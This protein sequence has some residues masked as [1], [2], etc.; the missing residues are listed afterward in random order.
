MS[1]DVTAK[2]IKELLDEGLT[3]KQI[4]EKFGITA[5]KVGMILA[6]ADGELETEVIDNK[7]PSNFARTYQRGEYT[8][9]DGIHIM[10]AEEYQEYSEAN[11]RFEGRPLDKKTKCTIE[12]L[13]VLINAGRK[14]SYIMKKHGMDEE[15][16]KQLVWRLS[17]KELRDKPL[18]FDI[19]QDYIEM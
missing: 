12:E 3:K 15:E 6:K 7:H 2:Q 11:G 16:F 13:R 17:T 5:P 14:P 19:K 4:G 9:N 10:T 18:R 1:Q 8:E